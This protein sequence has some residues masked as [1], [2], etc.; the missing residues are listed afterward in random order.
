MRQQVV[1]FH[2]AL[3]LR[4]AVKA[5]ADD[6]RH[7][8]HAVQTPDLFDGEVFDQLDDGIAKRDRVGI[9]GL[10]GRAQAAVAHLPND[11]VYAG[12]SMGA[13]AAE[14]LAATRPRARGAI[15]MHAALAPTELGAAVW[16]PVPLQVHVAVGDPF[17]DPV[18]VKAL[19]TA[20]RA[21][22]APIEV[23][24]YPRG[25]HLFADAGAADYDAASAETMLQRVLAMLAR[26]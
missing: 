23:F 25:G 16:P 22:G 2:S 24:S 8:G 1:L 15:L 5:F 19:E 4:P 18:A 6:L 20:A 17:V 10:I 21:A 14:F 11:V 7:A 9:P 3:G 26:L 12:F 13:A